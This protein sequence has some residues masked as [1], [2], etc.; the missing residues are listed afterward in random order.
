VLA[1]DKM[2][3]PSGPLLALVTQAKRCGSELPLA[4]PRVT[5]HFKKSPSIVVILY[6]TTLRLP[7]GASAGI[8]DGVEGA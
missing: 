5:F 7:G 6:Y 4:R 1:A 3:L 2:D 8:R